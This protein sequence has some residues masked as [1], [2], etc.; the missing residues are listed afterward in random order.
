ML[1]VLLISGVLVAVMIDP[2]IALV[3][4]GT[5]L[6]LWFALGMLWQRV[7]RSRVPL[8]YLGQRA[9]K[10]RKMLRADDFGLYGKPDLLLTYSDAVI[11]VL[12]KDNPAPPAP[13]EAHVLQAIAHCVLVTETFDRRPDYGV[14]WYGDGRTFEVDFDE[15]GVEV[16]SALMDEIDANRHAGEVDISHD[17]RGRCFA[18]R[19]RDACGQS[20]F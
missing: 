7:M 14:I 6:V 16:L 20:L 9:K 17:D 5:S 4:M 11:P 10:N 12:Q 1:M 13:Y 3:V 18:C 15:D 2:I 19:H 8:V